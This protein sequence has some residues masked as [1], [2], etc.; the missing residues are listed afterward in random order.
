MILAIETPCREFHGTI[1]KDGY[2]DRRHEHPRMLHR[3]VIST[4]GVDKYGTTWDEGLI[5]MHECDNRRCFRYDH[6]RLATRLE[7][8]RDMF[9]KGRDGRVGNYR[10]TC[11]NGHRYD[12]WKRNG[13][14]YLHQHCRTCERERKRALKAT[15]STEQQGDRRA[16]GN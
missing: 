16:S 13:S 14:G 3:W 8:N 10:E 15:S 12:A 6:L 11:R 9:A 5:V 4:A 7:N 1:N 2:G